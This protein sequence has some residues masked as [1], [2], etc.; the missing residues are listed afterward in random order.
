M[1]RRS[2]A[3]YS[4]VRQPGGTGRLLR[5]S[6]LVLAGLLIAAQPRA[7]APADTAEPLSRFQRT[8][9][10]LQYS[11]A[12]EQAGFAAAALTELAAVYAAEADLARADAAGREGRR[13]ARL[14]GW[15]VEVDRY[16]RE[17]LQALD[18]VLD[19]SPVS[20]RTDRLGPVTL[21]V[22]GRT[23]I[24]GHPRADQQAAYEQRVLTDFCKNHEC[25]DMIAPIPG[26][27]PVAIT[28]YPVRVN[29]LW[30]FTDG[31]PVCSNDGLAVY[32]CSTRDLAALRGVC[33]EL[34]R[35]VATLAAGLSMQSRLGV[36]IDWDGL[37]IDPTSAQAEHLVR[38]NDAGD[39]VLHNLPLLFE[40][41]ALL[42]DIRAYLY[43]RVLGQAASA[44]LDASNYGCL[45]PGN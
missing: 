19:G 17:L 20:L 11:A 18:E 45:Q 26:S 8:V 41:P 10:T 2:G 29:P 31:A 27:G 4:V 28:P 43:W 42:A 37:R 3:I 33:A 23:V 40:H 6:C 30:T 22:A 36:E 13:R 14:L 16:A 34:A 21:T 35:E 44:Q 15:S 38:L 5:G 24:L 1:P 32:F 39:S 9:G 7:E 25:Q 12:Q